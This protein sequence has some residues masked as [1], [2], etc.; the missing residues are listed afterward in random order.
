MLLSLACVM[1]NQKLN[2]HS[3]K[4]KK[5]STEKIP[6]VLKSRRTHI[7]AVTFIC[8]E[9]NLED[10]QSS[11]K[12]EYRLNKQIKMYIY[13]P[14]SVLLV[15][16][17][18]IFSCYATKCNKSLRL[19]KYGYSFAVFCLSIVHGSKRLYYI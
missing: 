12:Y 13:I 17:F 1:P 4:E 10:K 11:N 7:F 19:S 6:T 8:F 3:G 9:I 18:V 15:C 2:T 14:S 5:C 16:Y